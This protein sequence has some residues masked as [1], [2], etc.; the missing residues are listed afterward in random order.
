MAINK[1]NTSNIKDTG[2]LGNLTYNEA[3]GAEKNMEVGRKLIPLDDGTGAGF[4]T[5]AA[6]AKV[7]PSMGKNLAIYN[8]ATSVGAVTLGDDASIAAL[9]PGACDANGNVGIPC[10]PGDWTYIACGSKTFVRTTASTLLVFL[11]DD[12]SYIQQ[13]AKR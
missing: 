6:T 2:Q 1:R 11:I 10:A 7:L 9:A 5:N 8:N 4:T 12:E 3:S 13:E